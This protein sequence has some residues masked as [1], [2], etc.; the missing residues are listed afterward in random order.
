MIVM[1]KKVRYRFN[2]LYYTI[3]VCNSKTI[4]DGSHK[5]PSNVHWIK[6]KGHKDN[7]LADPFVLQCDES[8]IIVLAEEFDN[9]TQKGRLVK[10]SI[11]RNNYKIVNKTIVLEL[12]T[13]LSFPNYIK[14]NSDIYVYPENYQSGALKIYRYD[15]QKNALVEPRVL[16][17]EPLLDAA[18]VS[19]DGCFY[20]FAVK[21]TTGSLDDT[22]ELCIYK[23]D[24]LFGEYV[25]FQTIINNKCQERGAG[26]IFWNNGRLIRPVQNCEGGYGV[27]LIFKELVLKNNQFE[28]KIIGEMFAT[29]EYPEGLHTFNYLDDIVLIDGYRYKKGN[30]ITIAKRFIRLYCP[31]RIKKRFM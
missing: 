15:S 21:F 11:D 25:H 30:I 3:G 10:V 28:E 23:S 9:T 12:D 13:H 1:W 31:I 5:K 6:F 18:I 26:S 22:K 4:L 20:I 7:W 29:N 8:E 2:E 14:Y 16:I 19:I 24:S 17:N 27:N